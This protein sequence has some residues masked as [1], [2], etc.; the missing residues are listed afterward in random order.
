M[1]HSENEKKEEFADAQSLV[2]VGSFSLFA[3][4]THAITIPN[5][6]TLVPITLDLAAA[7]YGKWRK[8]FR[9]DMRKYVVE[10]HLLPTPSST[11]TPEWVLLDA[12]IVS[13]IC[14]LVSMEILDTI[15]GSDAPTHQLWATIDDLLN[16][17]KKNRQLILTE[18]GRV[19]QGER[20]IAKYFMLINNFSDALTDVCAPVAYDEIIL[21]FLQ[22][23]N[24]KYEHVSDL[25]FVITPFPTLRRHARCSCCR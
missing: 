14:G 6:K 25:I 16:D 18:L 1:T 5:I 22:G 8:F 11:R 24:E 23:L 15:M 12:T 20:T 9:A 21:R 17:H 2:V 7:T 3:L 19:S 13:W 4:H 10:D